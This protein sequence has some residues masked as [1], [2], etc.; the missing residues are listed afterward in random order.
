MKKLFVI[1]ILGLGLF[2]SVGFG[3]VD[4]LSNE[5]ETVR[6]Q[7]AANDTLKTAFFGK[8]AGARPFAEESALTIC[9]STSAAPQSCLLQKCTAV[10]E[11]NSKAC[12]Q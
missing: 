5:L 3:Q 4:T 10:F 1:S 12:N 11:C 9:Q 8:E 2:Q 6:W 7:C